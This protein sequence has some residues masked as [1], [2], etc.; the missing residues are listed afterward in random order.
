MSRF[1][2]SSEI[3]KN[4]LIQNETLHYLPAFP[5]APITGKNWKIT[6]FILFWKIDGKMTES[7]HNWKILDLLKV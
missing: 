5:R 2:S 7:S 6:N 3:G 4:F 1:D